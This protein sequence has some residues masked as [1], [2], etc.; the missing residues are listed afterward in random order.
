[1]ILHLCKYICRMNSRSVTAGPKG[2][3]FV[4]WNCDWYCQLLW[5]GVVGVGACT[6]CSRACLLPSLSS[7]RA[8]RFVGV[9]LS[10]RLACFRI[11][12]ISLV[13]RITE[14]LR[15]Q[16]LAL[17]NGWKGPFQ[18]EGWCREGLP[19]PGAGPRVGSAAHVEEKQILCLPSAGKVPLGRSL[20]RLPVLSGK[21]GTQSLLLSC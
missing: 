10:G 1:M 15:S 6:R 2:I 11:I 8:A 12:C 20:P 4:F 19:A 5:K 17:G 14:N 21:L 13:L 16:F 9:G 7:M 18:R 3:A